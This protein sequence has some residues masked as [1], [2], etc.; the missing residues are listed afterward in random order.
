MSFVLRA[1]PVV[2]S[3]HVD[4]VLSAYADRTLPAAKLL[5]CDQHVAICPGCRGAVEAE[6]RLLRSLRTAVAPDVP[7]RLESVLLGLGVQAGPQVAAKRPPRLVVVG[8]AAPAM[9]RSPMRAAM[10]ASLAAGVS[11]AAA[12]SVGFGGVGPS[13]PS[14]AVLAP[15]SVATA[16]LSV[17][18]A[19]IGRPGSIVE[20]QGTAAGIAG[21][22]GV[23]RSFIAVAAPVTVGWPGVTQMIASGATQP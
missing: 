1:R 16:R 5:A 10:L 20:T 22:I 17:R 11:A 7:S 19:S 14:R 18:E 15:V 23:G 13:A 21:S 8:R 3:R 12:W 4:A 2:D 6:R 9:H